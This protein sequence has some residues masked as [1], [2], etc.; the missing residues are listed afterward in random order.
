MTTEISALSPFDQAV[1]AVRFLSVDGVEQANSGHPG[2]PMGLAGIAVEIFANHLRYLPDQPHWPCRDRF[3]LSC[4]H[5]S[6][7][8]YSM[9]HLTGYGLT[10]DDLRGFRQWGTKTA[11]H[12]E[13]GHAPGIETTTGPLGQGISNSVGLALAGKMAATRV[14]DG[15]P[16]IDYNVY[17]LAS[18]GDL[19]E[20]VAYEACSLA[21][22]LQL[23]NLIV[24]YDA[25]NITIDGKAEDS[26]TEDVDKRF[27]AQG[28]AVQHVDGHDESG[29]R[30]AIEK[31]KAADRPALIIAKTRIGFGAPN[32]QNTSGAHGAP[33]GKAEVELTKKA[34]GWPVEPTFYAPEGAYAAFKPARDRNQALYQ[35]WQGRVAA[36]NAEQRAQ[37]DA[38]VSP[39]VPADLLQQ[40]VA[41]AG[42]KTDATRSHSGRIQQKV[43]ELVPSLIGGAADLAESTKT[44][45]KGSDA[46]FA[47][48][49]S[50]RNLNFGIR[51]HG[52]GSVLNGIALSGFFIPFGST[53]MIFSD[54]M[55]PPMRLAALMGIRVVYPFTHD[56]LF[57]GEDGPTHQP[58]EQLWNMRLV[59]NLD[60]FRPA[61][62]LECAAAW[63]YALGR[64]DGPTAFALTR[65][66]VPAL[67]RPDGFKPES[68]LDGAY[69]LSD[70]DNPDVV[71]IATG[72]EVSEAVIAAELLAQSGK[73]AR[74]VSMPC[75]D[76]FLRLS[77]AKQD[78]ILPP[79]VRRASYEL[80]VTTPWHAITG[81]DGI[82]IGV[83]RFGAS[84]PYKT[85]QEKYELAPAQAAN[86]ILA[87]LR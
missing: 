86:K 66:N 70:V 2:T 38:L 36:L 17:V 77:R 64:T 78:A 65:H 4:G 85:L 82:A 67:K 15:A 30:S 13:Y 79:G 54:Y 81:L 41:I 76:A 74:V 43:A 72:S 37:Y 48:K 57:L 28:W 59:P 35:Q 7:L 9:L 34:F 83:D 20:G 58:V 71:I 6:M 26:F 40:L 18:D 31:A 55:R 10:T 21:G 75:V 50:G 68:M 29:V 42:D 3:V 46:V 49:Y 63:A 24:V 44:W 80:G 87:A 60:V 11:G 56:S 33:L 52:M 22:H 27:T 53:F 39:H 5:A 16:L 73:K 23:D 47:G 51:E 62:G 19:M 1:L 69:V 61:D 14:N 84:A 45:I 8:L 25:N 32:K 12:P